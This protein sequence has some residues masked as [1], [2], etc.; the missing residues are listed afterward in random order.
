[1]RPSNGREHTKLPAA[2]TDLKNTKKQASH[3]TIFVGY[4]QSSP[5]LDKSMR[6]KNGQRSR[7]ADAP[8]QQE[9]ASKELR[10]QACAWGSRLQQQD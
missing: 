7:A 3:S 9:R 4:H 5:F 1:M 10:S 2:A 6:G 8:G